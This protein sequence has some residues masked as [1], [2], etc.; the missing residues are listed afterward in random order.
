MQIVA[1]S[2]P[3]LHTHTKLSLIIRFKSHDIIA[4]K[5]DPTVVKYYLKVTNVLTYV[6]PNLLVLRIFL[7]LFLFTTENW[8]L[9]RTNFKNTFSDNIK[10]SILLTLCNTSRKNINEK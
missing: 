8:H 7:L 3:E 1:F 2:V 10:K 5:D 4:H 6:L 9:L